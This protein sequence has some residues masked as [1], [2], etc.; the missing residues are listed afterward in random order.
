M[1]RTVV[2]AYP[3]P[4]KRW[5]AAS[6]SAW[7]VRAA[8]R[9]RVGDA[10]VTR[11]AYRPPNGCKRPLTGGRGG[12]IEVMSD[13]ATKILLSESEM[14]TSWYNIVPD[15]PSPPPPVLHPGTL[16]PVGPDDL[17]PLFPMALIEQE[18]TTE[19]YVTIPP[20]VLE[21]YRLWR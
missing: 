20:E 7:R 19:Q 4:A 11:P 3:S 15:L 10:L 17:A 14:P 2:A 16:Q 5:R 18:V 12:M 13:D 9:R 6:S 21:V 1:S 8:S